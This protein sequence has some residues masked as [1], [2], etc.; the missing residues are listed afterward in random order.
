MRNRN[1]N[2]VYPMDIIR[3]N[4]LLPCGVG[5]LVHR[6]D[7]MWQVDMVDGE[8]E[9]YLFRLGDCK[10]TDFMTYDVIVNG[11]ENQLARESEQSEDDRMWIFK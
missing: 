8:T 2:Q 10:Q 4:F 3:R 1:L 11:I 5:G 9:Q 7:V 6:A